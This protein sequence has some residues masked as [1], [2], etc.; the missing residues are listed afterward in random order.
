MSKLRD[1]IANHK[2]RVSSVRAGK[3]VLPILFQQ[4]TFSAWLSIIKYEFSPIFS[5]NCKSIKLEPI[6]F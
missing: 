1:E 2:A 4:I 5:R 6:Q 3:K